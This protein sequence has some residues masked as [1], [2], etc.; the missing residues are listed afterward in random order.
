MIYFDDIQPDEKIKIYDKGFTILSKEVTPF[1]PVYRNGNVIIP[2]VESEEA[3]YQEIK[4]IV[5]LLKR[6]TIDYSNAER[7]IRI[8]KL[9]EKCDRSIKAGRPVNVK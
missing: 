7:N 3:L 2:K 5:Q 1:K 4:E 8:I 6:P 9:L